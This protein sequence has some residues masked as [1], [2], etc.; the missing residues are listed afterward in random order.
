MEEMKSLNAD[1][2]CLKDVEDE[3]EVECQTTVFAIREYLQKKWWG[4]NIFLSQDCM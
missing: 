1:I 3:E 2:Y 4:Y